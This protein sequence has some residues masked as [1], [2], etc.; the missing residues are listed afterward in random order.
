VAGVRVFWAADEK[1]TAPGAM[2]D[3][4]DAVAVT[5]GEVEADADARQACLVDLSPDWSVPPRASCA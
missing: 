5:R 3:H 4:D 2:A 1:L